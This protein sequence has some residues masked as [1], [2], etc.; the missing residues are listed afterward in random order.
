M[1]WALLVFAILNVALA[2]RTRENIVTVIAYDTKAYAASY[3]AY[4]DAREERKKNLDKLAEQIKQGAD[5]VY[6]LVIGESATRDHMGCYGYFRPNTPWMS[7]MQSQAGYVL[8][9]KAWSCANDTVSALTYALTSKSQYN[10]EELREAVSI[11]DVANAAG[12]DT[13]WLSNQVQYGFADTPITAIASEAKQQIWLHDK[14]GHLKDGR[15]LD[16]PDYYD[17]KLIPAMDDIRLS[18]RMLIVIHLMGSHNSYKVRYPKEYSRFTSDDV[19]TDE[20][21]N[22]IFYTDAVL[23]N[24]YQK[25]LGIPNFM[26]MLYFS[27]HGEGIDAHVGH[28]SNKYTAQMTRIPM[29]IYMSPK[30][31]EQN[32]DKS[33]AIVNSS[34]KYFTNDLLFDTM[35]NLLNID[36]GKYVDKRNVIFDDEYDNDADRFK[37]S[38][39]KREISNN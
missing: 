11:V 37:T 1:N 4:A 20:Y 30:Y 3:R 13:V 36:A 23:E 33:R 25:A 15:Y 35:V 26:T 9:V 17:E 21:D 34:E 6:I 31:M 27:D 12:Y 10:M 7:S 2:F 39:G 19:D 8:F 18:P 22:S 29:M 24:I 5:G 32:T 38:Y 16:L 14:V 28:D